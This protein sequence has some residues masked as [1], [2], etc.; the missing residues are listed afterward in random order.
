[1]VQKRIAVNGATE[2]KRRVMAVAFP[3]WPLCAAPRNSRIACR[4][5]VLAKRSQA[6]EQRQVVGVDRHTV[7]EISMRGAHGVISIGRIFETSQ[8]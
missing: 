8:A 4:L 6:T 2:V 1:V 7:V 5:R 3:I